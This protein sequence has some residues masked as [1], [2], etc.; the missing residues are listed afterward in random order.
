VFSSDFRVI[1]GVLHTY[2]T[3]PCSIKFPKN[4]EEKGVFVQKITDSLRE[5]GFS[6]VVVHYSHYKNPIFGPDHS[7]Y[8]LREYIP[9]ARGSCTRMPILPDL[10]ETEFDMGKQS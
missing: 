9:T 6:K 5:L 7:L 3:C 2:E 10:I 1:N 8:D 4:K